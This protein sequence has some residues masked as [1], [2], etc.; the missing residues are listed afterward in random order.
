M[1]DVLGDEKD[2]VTAVLEG[3]PQLEVLQPTTTRDLGEGRR[4]EGVSERGWEGA[5]VGGDDRPLCS[6]MRMRTSGQAGRD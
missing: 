3:C 1:A 2:A 6:A 5:R 4:W